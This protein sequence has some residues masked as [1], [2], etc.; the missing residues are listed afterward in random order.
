[1]IECANVDAC[2]VR[3][4]VAGMTVEEVAQSLG[5]SESTVHRGWRL[6][7][8]VS[9]NKAVPFQHETYGHLHSSR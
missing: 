4:R 3:R 8:V 2:E 1:M 9:G 5:V 6:A 7:R